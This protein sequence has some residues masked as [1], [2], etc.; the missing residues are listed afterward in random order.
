MNSFKG[1]TR[2]HWRHAC[3]SGSWKVDETDIK[4]KGKW[5]YLYR[6]VTKCGDM[7]DFYLS[8][9]R[10]AKSAKRFLGKTFLGKAMSGFKDRERPHMAK[11]LYFDYAVWL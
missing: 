7:M 1:N 6:A 10:N 9:T 3:W 5:A 4:V 11:Q 8:P 2:W